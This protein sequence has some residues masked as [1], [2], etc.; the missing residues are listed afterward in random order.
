MTSLS[1]DVDPLRQ[2]L[3]EPQEQ[4]TDNPLISID[5]DESMEQG[6]TNERNDAYSRSPSRCTNWPKAFLFEPIFPDS[7]WKFGDNI[8]VEGGFQVKLI[9]FILFTFGGI[10]LL[11]CLMT[12]KQEHVVARQVWRYESGLISR[13]TLVFFLVGR[14]SKQKGVDHAL[15]IGVVGL[16]CIYTQILE[17]IP[18]LR[19]SLTFHD[20]HCAWPVQTWVYTGLCLLLVSTI[21]ICHGIHAKNERQLLT[22]ALEVSLLCCFFI[23]PVVLLPSFRLHLWFAGWLLGMHCNFDVWWSRAAMAWCWGIYLSAIVLYGRTPALG[24][25]Y[26]YFLSKDQNCP[27]LEC[28]S[29]LKGWCPIGSDI[30]CGLAES[31]RNCSD[32]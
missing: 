3:L 11:R 15:W 12:K 17:F 16:S 8:V 20:M 13:D 14:L 29:A 21:I 19:H 27:F 4:C 30:N 5:E 22:K 32:S 1:E 18:W 28:S 23:A 25:Q 6:G 24:C 10:F 7:D 2:P 9:K 31:W 26:A